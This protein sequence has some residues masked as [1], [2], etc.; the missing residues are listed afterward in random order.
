MVRLH[1]LG[2][3]GMGAIMSFMV[4]S[5]VISLYLSAR[6]LPPA[7]IGGVIGVMSL[8]LVVT[9]LLALGMSHLLGR[10]RTVMLAL[11]GSAI[12]FAS[13]PLV[14]SLAGLYLSRLLLGAV[15]GLLWPVLF[16]EVAEHGTV[17][18]RG[19]HVAMFWLYFGIGQLVAPALGG[20]LGE[21]FSLAMPFYAAGVIS[22]LTA[23]PGLAVRAV[24]DDSPPNPLTAYRDLLRR[25]PTVARPWLLTMCNTIVF[26]VY[27]TFLPLHASARGLAPG[28]IGWIFTAGALA[29]VAMQGLLGRLSTRVPAERF[30]RP[31]FTARG[32]G[33][34]AMPL[35]ATFPA[36]AAVN[37]LANAAGAVIPNA[38]MIRITARAPQA[39]LVP[40]M[41]AFNA[42]A[43]L[44][45]FLGPTVGGMLA[46]QGLVWPF[47]M[48]VPVTL[49]ALVLVS[50][51]EPGMMRGGVKDSSGVP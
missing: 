45:F 47:A 13:F 41:S 19:A 36:L 48:V 11:A 37:F 22:L 30:L 27:A 33:V 38:V 1:A 42:A 16:A 49:L 32:L 24:Q 51:P 29:F 21:H 17:E 50:L 26:S 14:R 25:A 12:F 9:E 4:T 2:M 20:W 46:D 5:P 15:R 23:V 7:H 8:A 3:I 31:A 34:A 18:A 44:G 35:F 39:F 6:S 28:S 10:R 40:A 43:D